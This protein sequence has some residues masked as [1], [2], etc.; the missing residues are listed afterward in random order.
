MQSSFLQAIVCLQCCAI[1]HADGMTTKFSLL[2]GFTLIESLLS[3]ALMAIL[4]SIAL[5]NFEQHWQI[6]RRQDAQNSLLQL[7][8][9]QL[10]WRGLHAQY[11]N[12]LSDLGWTSN[13]SSAGHYSL[14][15]QNA[16]SQSYEL[17]AMA[18]GMQTRDVPCTKMSLFV[19]ANAQLLRTSQ[20]SFS[21]DPGQCWRW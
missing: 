20:Q 11:T 7:H 16:N 1:R 14:H 18:L 13:A 6:S 17:H 4:M 12:S 15:L 8:L 10:Q 5:P 21:S 19:S 9:K 3:V 2:Q